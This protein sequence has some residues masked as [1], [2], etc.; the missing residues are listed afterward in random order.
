MSATAP[1]PMTRL[2][3]IAET[4]LGKMLSPKAKVGARPK[5]YLRNRDVQWGVFTL[6]DLPSMDFTEAES[7]KFGL[8][9][10]DVVVCEGGEVGRAAIWRAAV[11]DVHFQKALH[12]VRCSSALM[13][14][15]LFYLLRHYSYSQMFDKLVT[16]STIDHLPQE[17]LRQL[18]VPL[19]P[20][21]EQRRIVEAIEE[22]FSRLDAAEASLA[23]V[24]RRTRRLGD[25]IAIAVTNAPGVL[26]KLCE[27]GNIVTGNTPSTKEPR[28]WKGSL[29]FVT[30]GDLQHAG[31]VRSARRSISQAGMDVARTVPA[32]SVLVTCI[33]ATIGKTSVS[34]IDCSIN[35]QINAIV[36][37]PSVV[38]PEYLLAVVSG[39]RFQRKI[40]ERA[41]STTLPILSKSKFSNLSLNVPPLE[42]QRRII[43]EYSELVSVSASVD[44][45]AE[46]AVQRS[47]QLRSAIL[48]RAFA[49]NLVAQDRH[50]MLLTLPTAAR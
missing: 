11:T 38:L 5:P 26:R 37:D 28:Y 43:H 27:L 3:E 4:Q 9:R 45:M 7:I 42:T 12:R 24:L 41:S 22:Q 36:P 31:G 2:G 29:P 30:P 20:I 44:T 25:A 49:G 18:P 33:G 17:D 46:R 8:C 6:S 34:E 14:E 13:P 10:G 50:K 48:A 21:S 15:Y 23:R 1:W 39:P 35:Q 47:Y 19:P 40:H 16:G 32:H